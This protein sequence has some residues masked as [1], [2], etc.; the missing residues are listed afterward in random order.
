LAAIALLTLA[1]G[2]IVAFDFARGENAGADAIAYW[3]GV[4]TWLAGGSPYVTIIDPTQAS[5]QILPY[6]YPPWTLVLFLPWALIP[7][8]IA[9]FAWR[10]LGVLLFAWTVRWAYARRPLGTAV[11]IAILGPAIAANFDTGN[12]NIFIV[13][14]FFAAQ[15]VGPRFGGV[16]WALST[17]LKFLPGVLLPVLTPVARRFALVLL[18][19][20]V[21][22]SLATWPETLAQLDVAFNYPRPVRLDYLMLAWAAVPWIW[23]Q[24]WPPWWL[25]SR[26]IV[27]H[28]RERPPLRP[29]LRRFFS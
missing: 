20:F 19:F 1:G 10:W 14:A 3:Q 23:R 28:W 6:A 4:H 22:L 8:P 16:V 15:F 7:W 2:L 17:A 13:V 27:R 24:P 9:W 26:E 29:A 18:A 11:L 21:L 12:I 5:G 25:Q